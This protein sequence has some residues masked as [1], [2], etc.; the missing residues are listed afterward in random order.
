M[1]FSLSS[2]APSWSQAQ[3]YGQRGHPGRGDG[4]EEGTQLTPGSALVL[5]W[6]LCN[7]V[8]W[9]LGGYQI[10]SPAAQ[11]CLNMNNS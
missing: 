9:T 5:G 7:S 4:L 1:G 10:S 3:A 2:G 6:C 8:S 11:I